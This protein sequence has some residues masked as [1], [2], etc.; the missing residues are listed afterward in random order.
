MS[1]Q[2]NNNQGTNNNQNLGGINMNVINQIGALYSQLTTEEMQQVTM[3]ILQGILADPNRDAILTQ[4]GYVA[5][6]PQVNPNMVQVEAATFNGMM[7]QIAELQDQVSQLSQALQY[8][9]PQFNFQTQG[10]VDANTIGQAVNQAVN[11]MD[12]DKVLR[13]QQLEIAIQEN[14]DMINK[15]TAIG[16]NTYS[17][18]AQLERLQKER[19]DLMGVGVVNRTVNT[20]NAVGTFGQ[21]RIANEFI[22]AVVNTTS[23]VLADVLNIGADLV[24]NLGQVAVNTTAQVLQTGANTVGQV[25]TVASN[26]SQT[27]ANSAFGLLRR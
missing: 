9:Q 20:L 14:V 19:N 2:V 21:E 1:N 3:G 11:Q 17:Y 12:S 27:Y 24:Q 5:P 7:K 25:G 6:Q 26:A 23:G 10:T 15:L 22:P 4:A 18:R 8:T 16:C 13:I